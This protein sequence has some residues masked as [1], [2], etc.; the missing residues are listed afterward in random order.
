MAL[1]QA[2]FALCLHH[3]LV[4]R[5]WNKMAANIKTGITRESSAF[6]SEGILV[7]FLKKNQPSAFLRGYAYNLIHLHYFRW[8]TGYNS[9]LLGSPLYCLFYYL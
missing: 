7:F 4:C 8:R 5:F 9:I 6:H 3:I 1:L 2:R